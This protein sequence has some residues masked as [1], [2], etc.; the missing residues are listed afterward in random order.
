MCSD[1]ACSAWP[2]SRAGLPILNTR[3]VRILNTFACLGSLCMYYI[4][5]MKCTGLD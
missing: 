1:L 4:G 3:H 2:G 5:L